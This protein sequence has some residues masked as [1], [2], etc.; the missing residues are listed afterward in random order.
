[1]SGRAMHTVLRNRPDDDKLTLLLLVIAD[2]ADETGENASVGWTQLS[3]RVKA[4]K[5]VVRR[6]LQEA[7]D[8][9]W[10]DLVR[11]GG[12]RRRALYRLGPML[13]SPVGA[14]RVSASLNGVHQ[15]AAVRVERSNRALTR[16]FPTQRGLRTS[17]VIG[18]TPRT[19]R[20]P[21]GSAAEEG[22]KPRVPPAARHPQK[23]RCDG[24][25]WVSHNGSQ[26]VVRCPGPDAPVEAGRSRRT[27][28]SARTP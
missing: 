25:G 19:V 21:D 12:P 8:E 9:G 16:D 24:T 23:C 14:S 18:R 28:R 5:W 4:G 3:E 20:Q 1:M 22:G 27:G 6:L 11:P 15:T 17:N 13:R 2:H 26:E 7:I 10:L